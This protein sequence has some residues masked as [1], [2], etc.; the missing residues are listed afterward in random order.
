MGFR[1][2]PLVGA[3]IE[4]HIP[5]PKIC[6][7]WSLPS[8]ERGLKFSSRTQTP[9]ASVVAP[10]VGA[11]IE[12]ARTIWEPRVP[13]VAPLVGAW[14]EMQHSSERHLLEYVAPL[15]GA[16]IEINT[17]VT[18][19]EPTESLPSWERGLK[20]WLFKLHRV[21]LRRSPRGSVD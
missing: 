2:A 10:L 21:S 13:I 7:V 15:V 17:T 11:W 3:W 14:I 4:I 18:F 5:S 9:L 12:I 1:V 6:Q 20:Y 19:T 16:W 8:W